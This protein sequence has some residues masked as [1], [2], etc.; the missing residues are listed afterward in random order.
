MQGAEETNPTEQLAL[1]RQA[2]VD[3]KRETARALGQLR[4][5]EDLLR[6]ARLEQAEWDQLEAQYANELDRAATESR[7]LEAIKES[8]SWR[9]LWTALGPYR[10]VRSRGNSL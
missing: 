10:W 2:V 8:Q 6:A 4:V 5:V 1:A 3:A 9:L 7:E